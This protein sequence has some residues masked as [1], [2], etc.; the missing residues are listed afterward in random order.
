MIAAG[1]FAG[2]AAAELAGAYESGLSTPGHLKPLNGISPY[3][4]SP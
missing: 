4:R 1:T 2:R 3:G